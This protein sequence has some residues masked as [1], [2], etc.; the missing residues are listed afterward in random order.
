MANRTYTVRTWDGSTGL[1]A[2][3]VEL[4]FA[5]YDRDPQWIP[6][7][8]ADLCRQ[9]SSEN[10]WFEDGRAQCFVVANKARMAVFISPKM[11]IDGAQAAFFGCWESSGDPDVEQLMWHAAS[12]WATRQGAEVMYGPINFSTYGPY[13]LRL[14]AERNPQTFQSEPYNPPAYPQLLVAAGFQ[15]CARYVVQIGSQGRAMRLAH[16]GEAHLNA[17]RTQGFRFTPITEDQWMRRLPE[18]H[19]MVDHTF[20]QNFAYTPL[21]YSTFEANCGRPFVRKICPL[22]STL[23]LD[24]RDEI[25]GFSL[26]YPHFGALAIQSA[27]NAVPVSKLTYEDHFSQLA[28]PRSALVKTLATRPEFRRQG[29]FNAMVTYAMLRGASVYDWWYGSMIRSDNYSRRYAAE[30]HEHERWYGLFKKDL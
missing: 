11:V 7:V 25:V 24:E 3:F 15:V 22:T 14:S 20:S 6:E 4:P 5:I 18:L 10:A 16:A 30:A 26:I 8:T 12:T 1:D 21:P 13:R 28:V 27:P 9:F 2:D 19:A 29:I 23:V 17:L